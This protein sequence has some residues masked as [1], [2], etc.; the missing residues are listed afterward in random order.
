MWDDDGAV[1]YRFSDRLSGMQ[2]LGSLA[3]IVEWGRGINTAA[4]SRGEHH[5]FRRTSMLSSGVRRRDEGPRHTSER[6]F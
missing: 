4:K 6:N 5:R 1:R 3:E 2:N